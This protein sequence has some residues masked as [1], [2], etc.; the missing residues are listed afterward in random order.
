MLQSTLPD[1]TISIIQIIFT[2]IFARGKS[3]HI[4][5]EFL[6]LYFHVLYPAMQTHEITLIPRNIFC[7]I[8]YRKHGWETENWDWNNTKCFEGSKRLTLYPKALHY[9]WYLFMS[10]CLYV[11]LQIWISKVH[12]CSFF[13]MIKMYYYVFMLCLYLQKMVQDILK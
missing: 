13:V 7:Y 6:L 8:F 1:S 12:H 5:E 4:T 2:S 10:V 11:Y 9:I 3:N